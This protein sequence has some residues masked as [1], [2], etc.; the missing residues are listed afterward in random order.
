LDFPAL[1]S[2]MTALAEMI[3]LDDVLPRLDSCKKKS[4]E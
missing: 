3:D 4:A 1:Q 2:R